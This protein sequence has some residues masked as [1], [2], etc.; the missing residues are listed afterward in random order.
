MNHSTK[1]EERIDI[2]LVCGAAL[3]LLGIFVAW[4]VGSPL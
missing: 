4:L 3:V 1:T 2:G